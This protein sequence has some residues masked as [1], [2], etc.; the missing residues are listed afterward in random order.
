MM[1]VDA[2]P[3]QNTYFLKNPKIYIF[4]E[5]REYVVAVAMQ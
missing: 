3:I 2:L 5:Q 4:Y 1:M